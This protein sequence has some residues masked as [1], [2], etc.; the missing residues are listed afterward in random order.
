MQTSNYFQVYNWYMV[1]K[2]LGFLKQLPGQWR[3]EH[4][5]ILFCFDHSWA[6]ACFALSNICWYLVWMLSVASC[7]LPGAHADNWLLL[8]IQLMEHCHS[9]SVLPIR[10]PNTYTE[11]NATC[12]TFFLPHI[13]H[14]TCC[15]MYELKCKPCFV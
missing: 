7:G 2:L 11:H 5:W 14:S 13:S 9:L 4:W 15:C 12:L 1:S 3:D 8:S 6:E 10:L